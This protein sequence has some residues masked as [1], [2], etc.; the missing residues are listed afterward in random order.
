MEQKV[1]DQNNKLV[2]KCEDC[3]AQNT[4]LE[5][6][7]ACSDFH[8]VGIMCCSKYLCKEYCSYLCLNCGIS[9]IVYQHEL[10]ENYF[11]GFICFKCGVK[12][13]VKCTFWGDLA[14]DCR[15]YCEAGCFENIDFFIKGHKLFTED[16][17]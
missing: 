13:E 4:K 8:T 3:G 6:V 9:N 16:I 11:K 7:S 2:S 10:N 17:Q 12:T 14:R 1:C 5:L 15:R